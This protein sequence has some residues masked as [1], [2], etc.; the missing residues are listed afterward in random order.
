MACR[1]RMLLEYRSGAIRSAAKVA[2]TERSIPAGT[3]RLARMDN[4]HR[5][6]GDHA[7]LDIIGNLVANIGQFQQF[8]FDQSVV[9]FFGS[10]FD[11]FQL[12]LGDSR[13]SPCETPTL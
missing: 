6:S 13:P 7:I 12:R 8:L 3:S 10:V 11:V 1:R 5:L 4:L 9:R 2:V